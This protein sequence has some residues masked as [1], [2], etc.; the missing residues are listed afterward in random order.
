MLLVVAELNACL[1]FNFQ[2]QWLN[3]YHKR[4]KLEVGKLLLKRGKYRAYQWLLSR[5]KRIPD[6]PV[7]QY[8]TAEGNK[9]LP[10]Y[11]TATL[12]VIVVLGGLIVAHVYY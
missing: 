1:M 10:F 12:T 3:T 7:Y 9:T 8:Y 4:C 5:T 11:T 2:R 6:H